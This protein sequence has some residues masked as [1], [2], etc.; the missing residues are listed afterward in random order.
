[1]LSLDGVK[2][3]LAD[4]TSWIKVQEAV[5]GRLTAR[6][7]SDCH[8]RI[9]TE[10]D[11]PLLHIRQTIHHPDAG[12]DRAALSDRLRQAFDRFVLGVGGLVDGS[13]A[14]T[15]EGWAFELDARLYPEGVNRHTVLWTLDQHRKAA[16][17]LRL[18]I[19]ELT[20]QLGFE[21]LLASRSPAAEPTPSLSDQLRA[22]LPE[23][24]EFSVGGAAPLIDDEQ[25]PLGSLA[26]GRWY[27]VLSEIDGW[28]ET[29]DEHGSVGWVASSQVTRRR[30]APAADL[31]GVG[32]QPPA[33]PPPAPLPPAPPPPP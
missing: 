20:A 17:S 12:A 1:M 23:I 21:Q 14:E 25:Q 3:W 15:G 24:T 16:A 11:P 30:H 6:V 4:E 32:P 5:G 27:E 29:A 9:D 26:P 31:W 13:M 10:G 33:P 7:G 22:S 18:V 19:G 8:V 2:G 28:I